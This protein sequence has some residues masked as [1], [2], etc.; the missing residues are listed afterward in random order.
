MFLEPSQVIKKISFISV[1]LPVLNEE[2]ALPKLCEKLKKVL[3]VSW[4]EN[5]EIILVDDGS[6]D[7]TWGVI[8]SLHED[9]SRI[10]GI[11][12]SRNF[13]QHVAMSAGIRKAKGDFV[14][15]MD[16]DFQDPPESIPELLEKMQKENAEVV[17][18]VRKRHVE[19]F[20]R[21]IFSNM[22]SNVFIFLT[23]IRIP[24]NATNMRI[25][26]RK[27]VN[28]INQCDEKNLFLGGL[29]CWLG[30]KLAFTE[31]EPGERMVG[32]TKYTLGSL[33]KHAV[34]GIFS[35]SAFPLRVAI[36]LGFFFSFI[37]IFFGVY[38]LFRQI[39]LHDIV[40]GYSSIIVSIVFMGGVILICLGMI[41]E[42]IARI[43][44][45]VKKRPNYVIDESV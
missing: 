40:S 16:A 17:I 41:G 29:M 9:D 3:T 25:L 24:Y 42:Y 15:L 2:Q 26:S 20:F 37:S 39:F 13:G 30:F 8:C 6:I 28:V 27:V 44:D 14:A 33:L 43:Y 45:E 7:N 22:Y 38:V 32:K 11:K 5:F 31:I 19:G 1:V 21:S 36:I 23:R 12:F 34:N 4:V 35:F 10:H 18:G